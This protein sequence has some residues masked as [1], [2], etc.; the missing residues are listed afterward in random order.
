ME[1]VR[2]SKEVRA[3]N[4]VQGENAAIMLAAI[5]P[6]ALPALVPTIYMAW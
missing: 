5:D 2:L 1:K 3:H 4:V 6:L